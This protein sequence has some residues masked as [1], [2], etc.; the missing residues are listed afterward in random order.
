MNSLRVLAQVSEEYDSS[1][2]MVLQ[3]PC[4]PCF[5]LV[6]SSSFYDD[7]TST[8]DAVQKSPALLDD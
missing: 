8:V 1:G 3:T 6:E 2:T 5:V 7:S 4:P